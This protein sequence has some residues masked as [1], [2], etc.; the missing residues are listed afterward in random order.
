LHRFYQRY[1]KWIIALTG[2]A[3]VLAAGMGIYSRINYNWDW[4][5]VPDLFVFYGESREDQTK[6]I[7]LGKIKE[8]SNG[9]LSLITENPL[10]AQS[11][12]ELLLR[13]PKNSEVTLKIKPSQIQG[14]F[15]PGNEVMIQGIQPPKTFSIAAESALYLKK[16]G[17]HKGILLD[18]TLMTIFIS[19]IS[20]VFAVILGTITGLWRVSSNEIFRFISKAYVEIVRG[21]PLLVQIYVFYFFLGKVI[22]LTNIQAGIASL[23]VFAGA[24]VGEIIRAGIQSIPRGQ[25][26][27]A[28]SMG[29]TYFQAMR[30]IVM[31]QAFKRTLPPLAGQFISL[32]KDSSLVST[33]ALSD[34]TFS[35]QQAVTTT[36][37]TFEIWFAAAG[38][39]LILTSALSGFTHYLER[40]LLA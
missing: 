23:S 36:F 24:Y 32:I 15:R 10:P 2:I 12:Y 30:Y 18:G 26:E 31:P 17:W 16:T 20:I 14:E 5:V 1:K 38:V 22:G 39:Y 6:R 34:I 29:M 25:M 7:L 9:N 4:S 19:M 33:I 3:L 21:T 40:K 8:F 28:R 37:A 13:T 11:E 35:A 27:A